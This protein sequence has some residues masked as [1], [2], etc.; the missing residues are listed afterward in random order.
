MSLEAPQPEALPESLH[1]A[2]PITGRAISIALLLVSVLFAIGGQFT[3][4]SA[5]DRVGRIGSAQVSA[6]GDTILRAAKEPRLWVGLGLF[7]ISA[8]FW[9]VVLSRTPLS[10][11]YPFV[12]ISYILVV[13]VSR[14]FLEENVPLLRWA[15]VVFVALGIALIGL[16]FRRVTGT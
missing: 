16:S 3:L 8:L 9:L 10:V 14:V 4:K 7:G 6:A 12:G 13:L 11:A 2:P 5:M 15:G 1:A